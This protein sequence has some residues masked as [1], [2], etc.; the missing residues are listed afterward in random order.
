M[1]CEGRFQKVLTRDGHIMLH[2]IGHNGH[3]K[4]LSI[5]PAEV[6]S[7]LYSISNTMTVLKLLILG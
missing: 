1:Q 4:A 3:A 2:N 7:Y 6:H 5:M